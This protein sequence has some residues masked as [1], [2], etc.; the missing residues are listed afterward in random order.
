[1]KND[2]IRTGKVGA[3]WGLTINKVIYGWMSQ[4]RR[5]ETLHYTRNAHIYYGI[6]SFGTRLFSSSGTSRRK[7]YIIEQTTTFTD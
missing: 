1:M 7:K 2:I 6:M 5:V 4:C 3:L